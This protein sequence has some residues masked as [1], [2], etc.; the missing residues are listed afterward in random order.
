[1]HIFSNFYLVYDVTS[2]RCVCKKAFTFG[3]EMNIFERIFNGKL[4]FSGELHSQ[5]LNGASF[6]M[7]KIY[8]DRV[9][10]NA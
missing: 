8:M 7:N 5:I 2:I 6:D 4:T 1:M 3:G 9:N 10:T